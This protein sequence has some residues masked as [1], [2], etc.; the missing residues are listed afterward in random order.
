MPITIKGSAYGMLGFCYYHLGK[1]KEAVSFYRK[2]LEINPYFFWFHYNLGVVYF[3]KGQ[4][5]QAAVSF[6]KAQDTVPK[7]NLK[8]IR[9]S[10]VIY[11]PIVRENLEKF[12]IPMRG[13]LMDGYRKSD[14]A[15]PEP[16]S[17]KEL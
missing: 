15:D 16:L 7:H 3:K 6:K 8:F 2:A 11:V 9:A 4:Y 17:F 13:Q 1:H 10:K 5:E 12:S 14:F